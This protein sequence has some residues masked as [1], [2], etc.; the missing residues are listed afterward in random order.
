MKNFFIFKKAIDRARQ[1]CDEN[2]SFNNQRIV[3][4]VL[5][6][7]LLKKLKIQ[8]VL[9][10]LSVAHWTDKQ[11]VQALLAVHF[12]DKEI[13]QAFSSMGWSDAWVIRAF[14]DAVWDRDE[15]D[16]SEN[17]GSLITENEAIEILKI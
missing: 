17:D 6:K 12:T 5:M 8:H 1:Y 16:S 13:V 14:L 7:H 9:P 2:I 15:I 11:I 4:R 3:L 10:A